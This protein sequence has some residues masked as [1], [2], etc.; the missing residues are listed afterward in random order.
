M[1]WDPRR[2]F[3]AKKRPAKK[4]PIR[5]VR[6]AVEELENRVMPSANVLVNHND[7]FNDGQNLNE[8][9]LTPANVNST[10]FAKLFSVSFTGN[11]VGQP[12][13]VSNLNITKGP[14]QGVQNVAIVATDA[15]MVYAFNADN[16]TLLWSTSLLHAFYNP[17]DSTATGNNQSSLEDTPAIDLG[18]GTK[19]GV[20]YVECA[21]QENGPGTPGG[22]FYLHLLSAINLA[23]G[24]TFVNPVEIAAGL[25]NNTPENLANG[26]ASPSIN[27]NFL[28]SFL[29]QCR[30]FTLDSVNGVVYMAYADFPD[31]QPYFG[32]VIGYSASDLS[33]KA[34]WC[35]APGSGA[36]ESGIWQSGGA[37]A[38]DA[39]GNLYFET[40]NGTFETTLITA[41]YSGR[42][43]TDVANLQ[44]PNHGDYGDSVVKLTP[45]SDTSQQPD[46]PNGFGLHVSDYFTPNNEQNLANNDTDL[47]SS[48]P[49]LLPDSV[50]N[51][52]HRQLLMANDKQGIVYLIDR[53]N[54]GGYGG[55]SGDNGLGNGINTNIVQQLGTPSS[56]AT[57]GAW[58]TGAFYAGGSASS[59][60]I[61]Y[62]NQGD[63]GRTFTITGAHITAS[64]TNGGSFSYP[65][66]S[67]DISANGPTNGIVW[68]L[69]PNGTIIAY[70]GSTQG[71]AFSN[72][73][74][75][76]GS[77]GS[78]HFS[79]PTVADGE[80]FIGTN[81]SLNVY[82]LNLKSISVTPN[83]ASTTVGGMV[84]FTATGTLQDNTTVNLTNDVT[85]VSATTSVATINGTG[86]AT[87]ASAG[88]SNITASYGNITSAADVLTVT[89][90]TPTV[91]NVNPNTGA[92]GGGTS[93]TITG[94]NFT[95]TTAVK[96]GT[97][98]AAPFMVNSATS[99][100]ATAPPGT[101]G[102][103][104][105]ITVT[106]PNGTSATSAADQFTFKAVVGGLPFSDNFNQSSTQLSSN[107]TTQAGS[108]Q[109]LNNMAQ[110]V[111]GLDFATVNGVASV[112][113]FVQAD[114]NVTGAGQWAGLIARYSGPGD[115]NMYLAGLGNVGG[116]V[117][118]AS[119]WRN[120]GGAW[121]ELFVQ[122]VSS[123]G[124]G[125]LR[126]EDVGPSLK[127]FLNNSL[128]AYADDSAIS[129]AGTVGIRST[130]GATFDNFSADVLTLT[131][132]SLPF[133]DNFNAATNQQL[134]NSWLNQAGNFQ[135]AGGVA[136][137]NGGL[138]LATVNGVSVANVTVQADLT[139]AMAGQWAGL[140]ARYSGPGDQNMYVASLGNVG[141]GVFQVSIWRNVA[142]TW[143]LLGAQSVASGSGT[144][145]LVVSGSTLT[146]FF[147]G[148]QELTLSDSMLSAAG[149]VGIRATAG[150]TVDNF[151]AS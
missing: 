115:Q 57:K 82:G 109:V 118:Q 146:L 58:S 91:A 44:V 136:T 15:D 32:F 25:Q 112:N 33:L 24:S 111:G 79:R 53:N 49:V 20:L 147:G 96:F 148:V 46:N 121:T 2:W 16:G 29:E 122:T 87:G 34:V 3:G 60:T 63:A 1:R 10:D 104:V 130:A 80:V 145:R 94:T 86:L 4:Q 103:T 90:G 59:G 126:F 39:G 61:Y 31:T 140:I 132:N 9:A 95:G 75:S 78:T 40:G 5:R 98:M 125:T 76:N 38:V 43:S 41:P 89:G 133:S 110:A 70:N 131:N 129:G 48:S 97:T 50:G 66:A 12:L 105:D 149:A 45:D 117:F 14:Q 21:E 67:P 108:F 135:V 73:L 81:G 92:A 18:V 35:D 51:A 13:L 142:G 101:A 65:G 88:T 30:S 52:T 71:T 143:T 124:S 55:V 106:T 74:F 134:S 77:A 85:W 37:L 113:E 19:G 8:T 47:G 7:G 150:A 123:T 102:T 11:E 69:D 56:G 54:M 26:K 72:Q 99:I 93:V 141:G 137:G 42:L 83:P 6:L 84:Q 22:P 64:G 36:S 62:A 119:I 139:V 28:T 144:L 114:I 27:G 17:T 127:L 107:W 128:V 138:D 68:T 116:G 151:S 100:T 120:L 23:D